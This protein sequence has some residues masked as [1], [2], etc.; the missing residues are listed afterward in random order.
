MKINEVFYSIQGEIDVGKPSIFIRFSGCNLIK[1]GNGCKFCD[2]LYSEEGVEMSLD[3]IMREVKKYNCKKVIITGGES[4][5]QLISL[6]KLL[7][8]LTKNKYN[9]DVETNGTLFDDCL[10]VCD[11]INCSPKK[12]QINFGVLENLNLFNV[13]FKFVY[14]SKD[15]L[16]WEEIINKLKISNNRV[17]IMAEGKTRE[18]QLQKMKEVIEY[19]KRKNYNFT[20]R[21]HT[22]VW[23]NQKGV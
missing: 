20:P 16:W 2:S 3:D 23:D 10:W 21:L 15:D 8:E 12:Q 13:R 18:E 17:Y 11:N 7:D 1:D 9:V 22:L 4:L 5:Y 19:C 6:Q 14:E